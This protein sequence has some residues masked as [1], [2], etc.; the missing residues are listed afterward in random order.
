MKSKFMI[1]ASENLCIFVK[2][3]PFSRQSFKIC[4]KRLFYHGLNIIFE[5][6]KKLQNSSMILREMASDLL[7]RG[8]IR[9][10][11][12]GLGLRIHFQINVEPV[13]F[14]QHC[15]LKGKNDHLLFELRKRLH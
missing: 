3:G 7:S 8:H 4:S 2:L 14:R 9:P 1:F 11:P 10:P 6:V 15:R 13:V 5:K 12:P